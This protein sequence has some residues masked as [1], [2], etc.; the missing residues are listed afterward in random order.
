[1]H[2]LTFDIEDWFHILDN[3]STR[4]ETD[5]A[6]YEP[7]LARNVDRILEA[8][9]RHG[10]TA[11]FFCLGWVAR[12]H[13]GVLR[14]ICAH[15]HEIGSH[16]DMHQLVYQQTRAEFAD[17]LERS[18]DVLAQAT[19]RRVRLYRAP[20]FSIVAGCEWAFETMVEA[21]I[22]V[23]CSVFPATRTHG[24]LP[25]C[26]VQGPSVLDTAAGPLRLMPINVARLFGCDVVFSGGGYFRLCPLPLLERLFANSD[27]AVAYFHPRDFD[28]GQPVLAGLPLRRRFKSYVGLSG[29]MSKLERL[30]ACFDFVDVTTAEARIDWNALPRFTLDSRASAFARAG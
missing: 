5:W 11:T 3:P 23:D 27:Y 1:M 30:L 13:P 16:S 26:G 14:R 19:G 10:R 25:G 17:D 12:R 18:L 6:R 28:P 22:E 24:G 2:V 21:G 20:G 8:L 29:A 4:S 7:R 15:G 9:E